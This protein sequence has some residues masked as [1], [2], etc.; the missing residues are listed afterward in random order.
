MTA[1]ELIEILNDADVSI[2]W[3]GLNYGL[4][5][6]NI[7]RAFFSD[8]ERI[9]RLNNADILDDNAAAEAILKLA[10]KYS[11]EVIVDV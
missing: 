10:E 8:Y 4:Y 9:Q 6:S 2:H 5:L 7:P 1:N 3:D 11:G